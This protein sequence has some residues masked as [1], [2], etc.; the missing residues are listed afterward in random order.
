LQDSDFVTHYCCIIAQLRLEECSNAHITLAYQA[1]MMVYVYV[2][3]QSAVSCLQISDLDS[4]T[5]ERGQALQRIRSSCDPL[6][7]LAKKLV[8]LI[9]G[10]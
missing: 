4:T 5:E 2:Q 3:K 1:T 8:R 9:V 7:F 10:L 6:D